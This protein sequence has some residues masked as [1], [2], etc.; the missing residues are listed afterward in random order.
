MTK[1]VKP[2]VSVVDFSFEPIAEG[3]LISGTVNNPYDE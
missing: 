2:E 3:T 1:Y